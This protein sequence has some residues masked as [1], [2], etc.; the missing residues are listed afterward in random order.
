MRI[1]W[2]SH[3]LEGMAIPIASLESR[4]EIVPITPIQPKT[5]AF[6]ARSRMELEDRTKRR[7]KKIDI[8]EGKPASLFQHLLEREYPCVLGKNV[9]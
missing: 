1:A 2:I 4:M 5:E 9:G 7:G 8:K 3:Q 6:V